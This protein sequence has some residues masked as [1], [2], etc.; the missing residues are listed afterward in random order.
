LQSLTDRF[1]EVLK[2]KGLL[3]PGNSFLLAVSRGVDSVVLCD[4][5]F[6]A[7][8]KFT[9]AHCNFSLRENESER[10]EAF[11]RELGKRYN[12]NVLVKKFDTAAFAEFNKYS[13]QEAARLLR[14]EWFQQLEVQNNYSATL[15]AH[16]ANDNIE[17]VLMNFFRGTGMEGL[18]GMKES[19]PTGKSFRPMLSFTRSEIEQ[20]AL[21]KKLTWVEDSSNLSS[22]YTRNFF[23]N[24]I[25]PAISRVFPQ[26]EK[27][28]LDNIRRFQSINEFYQASVKNII[29]SVCEKTESETRIPVKKLTRLNS[30]VIIYEIFRQYG[31][32]EK[33]IG[34][35]Q[36]LLHATSGKFIENETHQVIRH[37]NWL[38]I[39]EKNSP[40]NTIAI[41]PEMNDIPFDNKILH[42]S[43]KQKNG[44]QLDR[45]PMVAQLDAKKIEFPLVLRKW[46]QGDYFYPLGMP[47]KKKLS[48]FFIDQKLP[49]HL[50]ESVWV[51]ES[52]KKI[53][54]VVGFRIDERFK[55]SEKSG[56]VTKFKLS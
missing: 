39:A 34:E 50:K 27:N 43:K 6:A 16:H 48:R 1:T 8:L 15:L 44:F 18:T 7:Q 4:L 47:K 40:A 26:V 20:Y 21:L 46:K 25:I 32:G 30:P 41:P 9:I 2:T 33:Q 53:V 38:L 49:K 28:L 19:T 37:G 55:V 51:L 3:R 24:E 14:Y 11:V 5:A 12:S 31:F 35:I 17:T 29:Q 36:K 52:N 13:I 56:Q 54:W 45:S 23:R 22:K 10:D 42:I